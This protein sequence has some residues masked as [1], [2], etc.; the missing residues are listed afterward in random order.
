[1]IHRLSTALPT[2]PL[3]PSSKTGDIAG[4]VVGSVAGL[5]VVPASIYFVPFCRRRRLNAR[6]STGAAAAAIEPYQK[7]EM[8]GEGYHSE[9]VK[10]SLVS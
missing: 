5:I 2:P 4:G 3:K 9:T 7:P 6:F 1:M 8:S 10:E